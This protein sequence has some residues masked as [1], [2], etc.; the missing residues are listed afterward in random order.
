[1]ERATIL[2]T[3]TTLREMFEASPGLRIALPNGREIIGVD[4][5]RTASGRRRLS[6][7]T[8]RM[9]DGWGFWVEK[10]D[11]GKGVSILD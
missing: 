9:A 5:S 10:E 1:M 3:W 4:W 11:F 7:L 2:V 8:V 6:T